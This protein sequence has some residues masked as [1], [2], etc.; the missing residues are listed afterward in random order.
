MNEKLT[1]FSVFAKRIPKC[2]GS[3]SFLEDH[4][5]QA[6]I[7]RAIY[8]SWY[9][10]NNPSRLLWEIG[11]KEDSDGGIFP[12]LPLS[13][14]HSL[15]LE[16]ATTECDFLIWGQSW[17]AGSTGSMRN[18]GSFLG[19]LQ[20]ILPHPSPGHHRLVLGRNLF[21]ASKRT[22][23]FLASSIALMESLDRTS[24]RP[25]FMVLWPSGNLVQARGLLMTGVQKELS[26]ELVIIFTF[27]L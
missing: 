24:P 22:L 2:P 23:F 26:Q 18:M 15:K 4:S 25:S 12:L 14:N 21:I 7:K 13:K 3:E 17:R 27:W 9:G 10:K 11:C 8:D 5:S 16:P 19:A 1:E 20:L 6:P